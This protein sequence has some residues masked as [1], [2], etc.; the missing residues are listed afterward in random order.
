[1]TEKVRLKNTFPWRMGEIPEIK[2]TQCFFF[3]FFLLTPFP[4]LSL[5]RSREVRQSVIWSHT[6]EWSM[7][8]QSRACQDFDTAAGDLVPSQDD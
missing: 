4:V 3:F 8:P 2:D 6:A 1:M 5:R 7:S